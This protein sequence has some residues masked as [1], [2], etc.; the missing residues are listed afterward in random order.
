MEGKK[1]FWLK[2][3][4]DF[5]KR[6][7]IMIIEGMPNG[8]MI[9]LFYLKLMLESIDHE[10]KLRFSETKPYTPEMLSAVFRMDAD[11]VKTALKTLE[12]FE[13][14]K[15]TEDG[16]IIVEKVMSMVGYETEWARKKAEWR[17]QKKTTEGQSEDNVLEMSSKCP[18]NVLTKKDNVRQEIEIEKE[19]EKEIE[20][21]KKR[22]SKEK[23]PSRFAPPTLEEVKAYCEERNNKVDAEKFI[24]FYTSNG[25]RV[26]KNPMKNWKAAVISWEKNNFND[27]KNGK[28]RS[29]WRT[30]A[31]AGID[32]MNEK[33][34]HLD[35]GPIPEDVLD[36]LGGEQA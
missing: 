18:H 20:I 31:E 14:I 21:D 3:K 25:W 29:I 32:L 23:T 8:N 5:F 12:D 36:M 1:Y 7:D 19:L 4:R 13:L 2:L 22:N 11:L 6:H 16:T 35:S 15:T 34:T 27:P 33:S 28:R 30:G 10:G 26:G 24:A 9:V 17:G